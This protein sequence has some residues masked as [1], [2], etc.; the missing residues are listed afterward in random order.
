MPSK[1]GDGNNKKNYEVQIAASIISLQRAERDPPKISRAQSKTAPSNTRGCRTHTCVLFSSQRAVRK[2][3]TRVSLVDQPW[4][5]SVAHPPISWKLCLTTVPFLFASWI[6]TY[7]VRGNGRDPSVVV[8]PDNGSQLA[9]SRKESSDSYLIEPGKGIGQIKL[10]QTRAR[11]LDLLDFET[12]EEIETDECGAEYIAI[13]TKSYPQGNFSIRFQNSLVC[14]IESGSSRYHTA[15]GTK[16]YDSPEKVKQFYSGLRAYALL[17]NSPM[18]FGGGPLIYWIDWSKGLAFFFASTRAGQQRYLY[19]IIVFK[20]GGKFCPALESTASPDWRELA[21]YSLE[22]PNDKA[23]DG[24][25]PLR[26]LSR[27]PESK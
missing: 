21:P 5:K 18:A 1:K 7:S 8:A 9:P 22:V 17:G 16:A 12:G 27:N 19:S 26:L 2:W 11:A 10:G 15:A 4:E 3:H 6:A 20:P 24:S 23:Q 13:D 14:Q 25:R